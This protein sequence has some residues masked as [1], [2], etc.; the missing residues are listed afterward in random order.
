[1]IESSSDDEG[2]NPSPG[3]SGRPDDSSDSS[4]I[5]AV[6][7]FA[8]YPTGS[9]HHQYPPP[10]QPQVQHHQLTA[11]QPR[12]GSPVVTSDYGSGPSAGSNLSLPSGRSSATGFR[13]NSPSPSALAETEHARAQEEAER[14]EKEEAERKA[15]LQLYV[16]IARCI[17]YPF[18]AKQPNDMTRRQL[19]IQQNQLE[20]ITARFQS[21]MNGELQLPSDG[22][23]QNAVQHYFDFFLNSDRVPV[24]V[25]GGAC[26][27][28]DFKEIFRMHIEKQ[29]RSL[30][31]IDGLSKETMLS[32]WLSKFDVL[33]RGNVG[34]VDESKKGS[35]S[36]SRLTQQQQSQSMSSEMI[37]SKEQLFDMFQTVLS[38]KKFE[39]QL[40]FNALQLDSADEQAAA[41][42]RE[43]DGRAQKANE[44]ER[45]RKLMPKFVLKEMECLY[46][47][48]IRSCV[49][50]LMTNLESLPVAKGATAI[51][52]I[53]KRYNPHRTHTTLVAK[54][55][56]VTEDTEAS[57]SKT[58]VVLTFT[59]EVVVMEV[60]GLKAVA[61]RTVYCKMEVEGSEKLQT[62]HVPSSKPLWVT[63]GDFTT[64]HPLPVVKIKLY[65]V[66]TGIISLDDKEL[67][68]VIINPTPLS[69]KS[70]E[71]F[72]MVTPKSTGELDMDIK[73][74]VRMD[75]P[76]NMK[77]CGYLYGQGKQVWKKWKKRYFVLVQV[78]Q[79][80]FAMCSYREKKAEP[81]E[82]LQLDQF[83]VDYI[84]PSSEF[85]EGRFFFNAVKEGDSVIFACDDENECHLWVM[86]LY[87]ATGQA[88]RPTP[89]VQTSK[90]S[91]MSRMQGDADRARKHGMDEYISSD[92]CKFNHHELL[93]LLQSETLKYRLNDPF[94]SL[95]WFSPGQIFLLDEY[96][97]RYGV[98][99]CFRH[100]CYLHDLLDFAEKGY[101]VDPTL[102]HY[103]FAFCSS[104]V[105]GHS[106]S[107]PPIG[108]V[109]FDI[110]ADGIGTVT[111]EEKDLYAGIKDR[112]RALLEYQITNF[113]YSF[114][115]GKPEGSLKATLSLLERVLMKDVV[116]PA[117]PDETRSVIRKCLENAA[118]VNY[119]RISEQARIHET[120]CDGSLHPSVKLTHLIRL[121][122]LC[123]DLVQEN[124]QHF[125]EAFAWFSDLMVEHCEIFWSLFAVDM[126]AILL[127]QPPD[128]WE[129]FP[130]FQV[131]NN[132]LRVDENM[133]GG[134]F[135]THIRDTFAP[136]VIRYVDL[137]E[138]SIAQ[139]L[140]RGFE[141]EKWEVE[142]SMACATSEELFWKLDALQV[143][144]KNL[145]W[146]DDV[147][148][149]HLEQ[150]LKLM[151][152]DMLES[153]LNRTV[154]AFH[155]C[156][157]K[158]NRL[159][160][161]NYIVPPEMCAMINVVHETRNQSLKLCTFGGVDMNQYHGKVDQLV[162]KTMNE[163]QA[164]L[165]SKLTGVLE[166]LLN[167]ISRYDE[168]SILAP[169]L[170]ITYKQ[171]VSSSGKEVGK[172][173]VNFVRN[174]MEQL[175]QRV[176]DELWVLN[177]L[178]L[179]YTTQINMI[180]T[181]LSDRIDHS[182]H[183]VQLS[184]LSQIVRK[185]YS[186]FALQGYEEEKLYSK[187][188][189]TVIN[190]IHLEE[191][192]ASVSDSNRE[193]DDGDDNAECDASGN[194]TRRGSISKT[195]STSAIGDEDV[196]ARIQ[197]ATQNV[198]GRI[199]GMSRIGSLGSIAN[200]FGGGILK[201]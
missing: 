63:Q 84:E 149:K 127:E 154:A 102:I 195:G 4:A 24:M 107:A 141:R 53:G 7:T 183:S 142:G 16:Y 14:A 128:S 194:A 49:S 106:A 11:Q 100:L 8:D 28:H 83:T 26:S 88:H 79:Y 41:I 60:R 61:D 176:A 69:V 114:P 35:T 143:F 161:V 135:H 120:T 73:I 78:S 50:Q 133:C 42:R 25:K 199:S 200:K 70:P 1:M 45:N 30:P 150:R 174:S 162:E 181:W 86:A 36:T 121:A 115:F 110:R 54:D 136:H 175:R 55:H 168:G 62:D 151:A 43:L 192:A 116:T 166:Q 147:L 125:A 31:E 155:G 99:S 5:V 145:H 164:G 74:I 40:L 52:K 93:K 122:E 23:F 197:N 180:C 95:G 113:R 65:A 196:V 190:R 51:S 57:L 138:S 92:P 46:L 48:E 103:S 157:R 179:W 67:G 105:H 77:H 185:M 58:D 98:R 3:A 101:M 89:L 129:T 104:H 169:I 109:A 160:S 76:Q 201:F 17:A 10:S 96:C 44:M 80:T 173:Y 82:M 38:I 137:M 118:L 71:W 126:E 171:G 108:Q 18:N 187:M 140:H 156:E 56:G 6:R 148:A 64:T 123:V 193:A 47:E 87:R 144:I 153:S 21:F 19:K 27:V 72:K 112:L 170:S 9:S 20:Q 198:M 39:H 146:P 134:R 163:M 34:D 158:G 94:C 37:L 172:A 22:A 33:L 75:K 13:P 130:L 182:L 97:A 91:T 139:S 131:L 152:C 184:A 29:I 32:S 167:K 132:Y 191:A 189:Q 178:E 159:N 90:N 165:I 68:K 59:I 2:D 119:S 177:L 186:E 124:N 188:Y 111:V 15:R 66:S 81:T 85:E 12:S 117:S